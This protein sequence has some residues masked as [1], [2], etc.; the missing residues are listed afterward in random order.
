VQLL[1]THF[2]PAVVISAE[3]PVAEIK[4][5]RDLEVWVMAME[6]ATAIYKLTENFPSH[7][8]YGIIAQ[9]RRAAVSIP[10]NVA[11]GHNRRQNGPYRNHVGIALGSQG[12][13]DTLIEL[14]VRLRY[15]S[16]ADV[17][18]TQAMTARVGQM[19]SGLFRSLK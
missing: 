3:A 2:A 4:S 11:E 6:L 19:L 13:L 5:F 1:R 16:D 15:A 17:L 7:E 8:Q 14:S 10:A 12:E 9:I 18:Q